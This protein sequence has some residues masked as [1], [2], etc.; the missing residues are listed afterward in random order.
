MK[1]RLSLFI[2]I[3]FVALGIFTAKKLGGGMSPLAL[4]HSNLRPN[5]PYNSS[6]PTSVPWQENFVIVIVDQI[7]NEA[8]VDSIWYLM[9][10]KEVNKRTMISLYPQKTDNK[11]ANP[12]AQPMLINAQDVKSA[13]NLEVITSKRLSIDHVLIVDETFVDALIAMGDDIVINEVPY[14]TFTGVM[15]IATSWNDPNRS[16]DNQLAVLLNI[17][18]TNYG[19]DGKNLFQTQGFENHVVTTTSLSDLNARWNEMVLT[20]PGNYCEILIGS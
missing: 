17:C 4:N 11:E 12:D 8:K 14:Q 5:Q 15:E 6:A 16:L 19:V 3:L 9:I 10:D 2:F 20:T 13:I 18:G 1:K 7:S